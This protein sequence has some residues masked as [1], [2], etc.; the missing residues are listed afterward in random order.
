MYSTK[1]IRHTCQVEAKVYKISSTESCRTVISI[2]RHGKRTHKMWKCSFLKRYILVLKGQTTWYNSPQKLI[3]KKCSVIQGNHLSAKKE[4][5][6]KNNKA[7]SVGFWCSKQEINSWDLQRH[8][9]FRHTKSSY[10]SSNIA[11][12]RLVGNRKWFNACY[13]L[14]TGHWANI[15]GQDLTVYFYV[16]VLCEWNLV[17]EMNRNCQQEREFVDHDNRSQSL[18][19]AAPRQSARQRSNVS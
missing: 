17:S 18:C 6:Q 9:V 2:P 11:H 3:Q 10:I 19:K 7:E 12:C 5:Q 15:P 13:R 8:F 1:I 14:H 16:Q 4:Q